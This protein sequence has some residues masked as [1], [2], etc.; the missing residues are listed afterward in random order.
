[1]A[2]HQQQH[3]DS[4]ESH[5]GSSIYSPSLLASVQDLG[6]EKDEEHAVLL[7][8]SLVGEG[9]STTSTACGSSV[10]CTTSS[11]NVNSL[12]DE[13]NHKFRKPNGQSER[14]MMTFSFVKY[15]ECKMDLEDMEEHIVVPYIEELAEDSIDD[16]FDGD[17]E[18]DVESALSLNTLVK[19]D[20][21]IGAAGNC[22]VA[23]C[24]LPQAGCM[25]L[26]NLPGC[27]DE[28]KEPDE[29]RAYSDYIYDE[30]YHEIL[31]LDEIGSIGANSEADATR[32][33]KEKEDREDDL[34]LKREDEFKETDS[35]RED[36]EEEEREDDLAIEDQQVYLVKK[37]ASIPSSCAV[38]ELVAQTSAPS[39]AVS[40]TTEESIKNNNIE[41]T[42]IDLT[43]SEPV[44]LDRFAFL[45]DDVD[46]RDKLEELAVIVLGTDSSDGSSA[47]D[48]SCDDCLDQKSEQEDASQGATEA[49]SSV[50]SQAPCDEDDAVLLS[51]H[52]SS[53]ITRCTKL[54]PDGIKMQVHKDD[55]KIEIPGFT[56]D[57]NGTKNVEALEVL[58]LEPAWDI[59]EV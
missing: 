42:G 6:S 39:D 54:E 9:S 16:E 11:E 27:Q 58:H 31:V 4:K 35:T 5:L 18:E 8:K 34:Y 56:L 29:F 37:E 12:I 33:E 41:M 22:K 44:L 21:S 30:A 45:D 46:D 50:C 2:E 10:A 26:F 53:S 32:E 1:M 14:K 55:A 40:L 23:P 51:Q 36:K 47:S 24:K 48:W 17:E 19:D 13:H 15:F 25:G 38:S 57:P 59:L 52:A 3:L 43:Q 20:A 28:E 7:S 49:H